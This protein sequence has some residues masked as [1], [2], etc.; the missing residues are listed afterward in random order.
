MFQYSLNLCVSAKGP[1]CA[2]AI[3]IATNI[4]Q[5]MASRGQLDTAVSMQK[6]VLR[7]SELVL[8]IDNVNT[9]TILNDLA[10][11]HFSNKNPVK[12]IECFLKSLFISDL[13]GGEYNAE[14]LRL[15]EEL[16]SLYVNQKD[17]QQAIKCCDE[18]K[19]RIER[20]YPEGHLNNVRTYQ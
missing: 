9:I 7:V 12:A 14:S 2:Q 3:D 17:L 16:L 1:F 8:G 13:I 11:F 4:A 5:L 18:K 10:S 6:N 19:S 15:L 20:L